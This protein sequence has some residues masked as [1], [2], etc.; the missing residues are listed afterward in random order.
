MFCLIFLVSGTTGCNGGQADTVEDILSSA[1]LDSLMFSLDG[2]IY[3]LPVHFSELEENGWIPHDP[4]K[5]FAI[6]TLEPGDSVNGELISDKQNVGVV[7]TN[8][9]EK[10]LLVRESHITTVAVLYEVYNAK[11]MLPGNIMIGSAVEDVFSVYGAPDYTSEGMSLIF[12]NSDNYTVQL[13]ID[14]E[15]NEITMT[16]MHYF[17]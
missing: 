16:S 5:S 12:Y 17:S 3:T 10:A 15:T 8:L 13:L 1:T 4:D 11:I 6:S 2:V 14:L 7:F 9:S